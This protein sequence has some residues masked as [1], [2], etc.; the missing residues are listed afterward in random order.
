MCVKSQFLIFVSF[1]VRI[2]VFKI[3]DF[4]VV[5]EIFEIRRIIAFPDVSEEEGGRGR[6]ELDGGS[7]LIFFGFSESIICVFFSVCVCALFFFSKNMRH[8]ITTWRFVAV[9][10]A[11]NIAAGFFTAHFIFVSLLPHIPHPL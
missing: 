7:L 4:T 6:R 11:L 2:V 1:R 5:R 3:A 9:V 8:M 10:V